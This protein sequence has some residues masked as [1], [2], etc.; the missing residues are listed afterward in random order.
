M[1]KKKNSRWY[2]FLIYVVIIA[3]IGFLVYFIF[4]QTNQRYKTI[5]SSDAIQLVQDDQDDSKSYDIYQ[6]VA[7]ANGN[8]VTFYFSLIE[9]SGLMSI[10]QSYCKTIPFC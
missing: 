2:S 6:A 1:E 10:L 7:E 3:L 5:A 8:Q 9:E 4:N